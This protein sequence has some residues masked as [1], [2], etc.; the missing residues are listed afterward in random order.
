[1]T[2]PTAEAIPPIHPPDPI[3]AKAPDFAP[4]P[5][6]GTWY[7]QEVHR[8]KSEC[9]PDASVIDRIR[10]AAALVRN[11]YDEPLRLEQLAAAASLSPFH[12][13]RQFRRLY[14]RTPGQYLTSVRIARAAELLRQDVPVRDACFAVGFQSVQS[15][16]ILFRKMTGKTPGSMRSGGA[17][18]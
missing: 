18:I 7:E 11:N 5:V 8:L 6:P 9:Y 15:F 12:F 10:A 3:A 13:T 4:E 16:S 14:G 2:A 17:I 1:M